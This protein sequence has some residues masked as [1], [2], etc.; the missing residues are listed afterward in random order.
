MAID[1]KDL[2]IAEGAGRIARAIESGENET[3][4]TKR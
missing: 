1:R 3:M 2:H 4:E